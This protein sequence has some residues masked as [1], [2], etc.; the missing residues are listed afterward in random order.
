[1][2]HLAHQGIPCPGSAGGPRDHP[3]VAG[4]PAAMARKLAGKSQL[5]PQAV[6]CTAVGN[7]GAHAPGRARLRS[8]SNPIC[9]PALVE[10]DRAVVLPLHW[11]EQVPVAIRA[12]LPEQCGRQQRYA[13][14]CRA[15][16]IHADLFRDNVMFGASGSPAASTFI[17]RGDDLPGC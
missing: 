12:G 11:P 13:T 7:A 2:K 15:A 4:K 8:A 16:Y 9:G 14:R 10:R 3:Q 1:M 17:S 6:H 5:A